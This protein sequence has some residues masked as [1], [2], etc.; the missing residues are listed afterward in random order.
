MHLWPVLNLSDGCLS[1]VLQVLQRCRKRPQRYS[2]LPVAGGRSRVFKSAGFIAYL[3]GRQRVGML[4]APCWLLL[5]WLIELYF[6]CPS[7]SLARRH[8]GQVSKSY[9]EIKQLRP[10]AKVCFRHAKRAAFGPKPQPLECAPTCIWSADH[11]S[12]AE[13]QQQQVCRMACHNIRPNKHYNAQ[14]VSK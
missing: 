11:H 4:S 8:R 7:D 10:C 6:F 9:V 14:S 1:R 3:L 13:S 2:Q 12:H 5:V